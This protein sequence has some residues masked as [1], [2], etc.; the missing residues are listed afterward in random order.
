MALPGNPYDGHSLAQVI[1][2]IE[3]LLG[4]SPTRFLADR[5]YKGH[6][7]PP[8]YKL[9]VYIQGQKRR[10][11]E[12]IKRELKRRSAV[13]PVIGH[14][15]AEHRM[16]RNYLAHSTGDATNAMLA[17]VGYNFRRLLAWLALLCAQI[18]AA[19]FAQIQPKALRPA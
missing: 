17:A 7:A 19:L 1:P 6:K 14:M 3:Q 13:E 8:A 16:D 10:M 12:Q 15:K 5:G 18:L 11:T 4:N 9:K 2:S